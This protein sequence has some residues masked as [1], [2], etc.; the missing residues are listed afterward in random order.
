MGKDERKYETLSR[1]S[2][3]ICSMTVIATNDLQE[4]THQLFLV[5]VQ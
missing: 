1:C 3:R 5:V 4:H 2:I